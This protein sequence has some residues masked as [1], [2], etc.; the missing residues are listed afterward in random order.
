MHIENL[1]FGFACNSSSTHSVVVVPK[2]TARP[3]DTDIGTHF[4]WQYFVAAS[5]EAKK[6][7]LKDI[8]RGNLQQLHRNHGN[9]TVA[10]R[11]T[12]LLFGA[13]DIEGI[14]HQSFPIIPLRQGT[15]DLDMA[16]FDALSAY[17]MREDVV[18]LGGNDN[19]GPSDD[20]ASAEWDRI[21][22]VGTQGRGYSLIPTDTTLH[23]WI[24]RQEGPWW[25]LFN[26][27][28]GTKVT[29]SFDDNPPVR[30]RA[31]IPELVDI[32]IT[33]F[34]PYACTYCYQ[35][36]TVKGGHAQDLSSWLHALS[37]W[38]VFEVAIG[39]GEPTLHPDFES[40][41]N[42]VDKMRVNFTTRNMDWIAANPE[43][44]LKAGAI[45]V[46]VDKY[47]GGFTK[48][49][50]RIHQLPEAV[51]KKIK[52]QYVMG[53]GSDFDFGAILDGAKDEYLPITLLG[54]KYTGRGDTA[55]KKR[56]AKTPVQD[57]DEW[58]GVVQKTNHWI[59]IDTALAARVP[60][61]VFP[62]HLLRRTEGTHSCYIDAVTKKMHKDS[63]SPGEGVAV[64]AHIKSFIEAFDELE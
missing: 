15:S 4:G 41:F 64:V 58:I 19:S 21:N 5:T 37:Y 43:L 20:G 3:R 23:P 47:H 48:L 27:N 50:P 31:Q 18:I 49:L 8:L 52:L 45:A 40:V 17:I 26:R 55:A 51:R 32:K 46:S 1:R 29:L 35:D 12:D 28:E 42:N 9:D 39:G 22:T 53:S 10:T 36:S 7:Y 59:S 61:D 11:F 16:F 24:S 38:G 63:Y 25:V 33:D 44:A 2:G 30:K 34:C 13:T 14:D 62:E 56:L 57:G 60:K 6:A 54:Y